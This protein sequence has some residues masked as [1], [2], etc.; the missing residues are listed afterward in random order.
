M[1]TYDQLPGPYKPL[2][3]NANFQLTWF[4]D[5][6]LDERIPRYTLKSV[7]IRLVCPAHR[8]G[9]NNDGPLVTSGWNVLRDIRRIPPIEVMR[10]RF[11]WHSVSVQVDHYEMEGGN[12]D[13]GRAPEIFALE[14]AKSRIYDNRLN[15]CLLRHD[16]TLPL[17]GTKHAK[18]AL[19]FLW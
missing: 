3:R 14:V 18:E 12:F 19:H 16:A 7:T 10:N 8:Y 13:D 4:L 2:H 15:E 11:A 17:S 5:Q 9:K 1:W 6:V